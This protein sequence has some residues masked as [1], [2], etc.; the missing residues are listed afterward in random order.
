MA[1]PTVKSRWLEHAA[2]VLKEVEGVGIMYL[3]DKDVV[4]NPLVMKIVRAYDSDD[5]RRLSF[6]DGN[7]AE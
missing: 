5:K 1:L 6:A 2:T 7:K 3:T 4:R